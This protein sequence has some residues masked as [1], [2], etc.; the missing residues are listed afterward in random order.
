MKKITKSIIAALSA[1]SMLAASFPITANAN[2]ETIQP[3]GSYHV[4]GD[5]NNDGVITG[6]DATITLRSFT[7]FEN[8]TGSPN[9]PLEYA[10][11]RPAVY[12]PNEETPVPQAADVNGDGIINQADANEILR[13]YTLLSSGNGNPPDSSVYNGKCGKVFYIP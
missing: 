13:Y 9:L 2:E 11:A 10:I 3:R 8:L 4:Y 1:S 5:V 12:F 7:I 6:S